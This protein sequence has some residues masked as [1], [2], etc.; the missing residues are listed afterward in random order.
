MEEI[1]QYIGQIV[2]GLAGTFLALGAL[3]FRNLMSRIKKNEEDIIKLQGKLELNTAL[4]KARLE[5]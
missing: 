1:Q 4:D 3:T 2:I 5:K